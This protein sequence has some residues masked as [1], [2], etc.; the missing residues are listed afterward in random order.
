MAS[1]THR[2]YATFT[3]ILTTQFNSLAVGSATAA[4]SVIDN[5][6]GLELYLD[7]S[8]FIATMGVARSSGGSVSVYIMHALDGT[9][10]DDLL[11]ETAEILRTYPL[12][13]STTARRVTRRD[14]P[15]PPGLF[16]LFAVNNTGQTLA[17]TGNTFGYRLHSI[18]SV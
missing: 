11:D 7:G 8:L 9:N 4:S 16:K 10:Y 12:D 14:F 6:S 1:T 13:A 5:T 15:C 17:A 3:S 2:A 18:S